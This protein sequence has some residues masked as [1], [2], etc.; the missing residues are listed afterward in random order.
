MWLPDHNGGEEFYQ[1]STGGG[2][3]GKTDLALLNKLV[4]PSVL[5]FSWA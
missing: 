3:P 1:E 4:D 5:W 2:R